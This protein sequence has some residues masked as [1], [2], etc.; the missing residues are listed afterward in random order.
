MASGSEPETPKLIID[1][2]W[3][4]QARAEK[5]RLSAKVETPKPAAPSAGG[6][7]GAEAGGPE[8][9][10]EPGIQDIISLLMTQALTYM[11]AFPDPRTGRAVVS[12]EMAKVFIE[13]LRVLEEKTKGNLNEQEQTVISRVLSEL[14]MEY[15]EVAKY[16]EQAIAEGKVK[17]VGPG[18][19]MA[20]PPGGGMGMPGPGPMR[21]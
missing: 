17:S 10:T 9:P 2:D 4:S 15:V 7:P 8:G 18:G 6:A 21:S 20:A 1:S 11:G 5:E 13:L 16:V 19:M 14:R 3:K 12:L